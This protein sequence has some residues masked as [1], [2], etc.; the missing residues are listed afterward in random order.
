MGALCREDNGCRDQSYCDGRGTHCPPS[1]MK[2]NKTVC[3][4]EFVCFQ[5]ECT[6]SICLAYGLESCQCLE[7]PGDSPTKVSY[8]Y[9]IQYKQ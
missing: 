5:G 7:G 9:A 8:F 1:I 6:G 2:P 3:N 4:Q